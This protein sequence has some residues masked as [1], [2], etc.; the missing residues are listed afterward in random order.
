MSL[1]NVEIAN[2]ALTKG[3]SPVTVSDGVEKLQLFRFGFKNNT[4]SKNAATI[5][6]SNHDGSLNLTEV[7]F[8]GNNGTKDFVAQLSRKT[9]LQDVEVAG[10]NARLVVLQFPTQADVSIVN[11][12]ANNNT[13]T[14]MQIQENSTAFVSDSTFT[15]NE[16]RESEMQGA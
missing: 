12:T 11:L 9:F 5:S 7:Q 15:D 3:D 2:C 4:H 1:Q 10:N 8:H 16:N 14:V 6:F 13:G